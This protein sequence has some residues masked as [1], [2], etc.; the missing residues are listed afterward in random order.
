M[1]TPDQQDRWAE[2]LEV[3]RLMRA[4]IA[5]LTDVVPELSTLDAYAIARRGIERR[6]AAGA[7]AMGHKIGLTSVAVQEQLG[8]EQPDYGTL[9]DE[10]RVADGAVVASAAFVSPKVE[11]EL[12]FHLA[13]PL[14]GPHAGIEDVQ[15]ATGSV[16]PAIEIVDSRIVDWRIALADTIA[17]NASSGAFVLGGERV[18]PG[19]LDLPAVE[20]RL[21]RSGDVVERGRGDAVLGDPRA[22]VA[23]LANALWA[24]GVRLEPGHIV[25][26]GA[27]TRMV[28]AAAGDVFTG[29]FGALG[30]VSVSFGV[31]A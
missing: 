3:A 1:L 14:T 2:E 19:E 26:S 18:P 5:P 4:P 31:E 24:H 11:L 29:D 16:Q 12:A 25:L 21:A 27:C 6:V 23:W 8:V 7:T 15:R 22:A 28:A 30:T 20:M 9:L 13:A 10:M 17:D